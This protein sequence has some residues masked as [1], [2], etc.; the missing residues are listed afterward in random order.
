MSSIF[1]SVASCMHHNAKTG[2]RLTCKVLARSQTHV[3]H[4][5]ISG[6]K[7]TELTLIVRIVGAPPL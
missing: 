2:C 5:Y 6:W 3:M 1:N 7:A 4:H